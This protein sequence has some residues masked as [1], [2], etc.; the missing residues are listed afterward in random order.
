M[1]CWSCA[2]RSDQPWCLLSSRLVNISTTFA[3]PPIGRSFYARTSQELGHSAVVPSAP[4]P[5]PPLAPAVSPAAG[6]DGKTGVEEVPSLGGVAATRDRL[7]SSLATMTMAPS[8]FIFRAGEEGPSEV[9]SMHHPRHFDK[10]TPQNLLL[11][12]SPSMLGS[13]APPFS[14]DRHG[15]VEGRALHDVH[16]AG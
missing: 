2:L 16:R 7:S 15:E 9:R 1:R 4:L 12:C 11:A 13:H 3:E 14:L 5:P 6:A 10:Q 8:A